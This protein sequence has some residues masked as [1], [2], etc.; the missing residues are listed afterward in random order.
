MSLKQYKT[1]AKRIK[2]LIKQYEEEQKECILMIELGLESNIHS[3]VD[4][5]CD[6]W[7]N[8][9]DKINLLYKALNSLEHEI[10][11]K[12]WNVQEL[13]DLALNNID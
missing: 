4:E 8:L 11:T 5:Y 6:K 2:D 3:L 9:E 7:S 10:V 1:K 12:S 13:Y